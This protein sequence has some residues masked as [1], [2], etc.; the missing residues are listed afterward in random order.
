VTGH[1][2]VSSQYAY[3]M[4]SWIFPITGSPQ[5]TRLPFSGDHGSKL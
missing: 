1:D 5:R 4:N 3:S 2:D